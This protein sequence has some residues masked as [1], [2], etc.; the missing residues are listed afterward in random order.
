M[1][2]CARA[3]SAAVKRLDMRNSSPSFTSKMSRS[4]SERSR[5]RR[6]LSGPSRVSW[7]ASSWK[8]ALMVQSAECDWT[9]AE[10]YQ[11]NDSR[12]RRHDDL[13]LLGHN[14]N[15]VRDLAGDVGAVLAFQ[16]HLDAHLHHRLQLGD[17]QENLLLIR[18]EP[19][20]FDLQFIAA[21]LCRVAHLE[22]R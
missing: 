9:L 17:L 3:I 22:F 21:F 12:T 11:T 19:H 13:A 7:K 2:S 1:P 5:R 15:C 4:S 14:V 18:G 8:L 20:T 6:K 16:L 10:N